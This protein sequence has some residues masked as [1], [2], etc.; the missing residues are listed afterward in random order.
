MIERFALGARPTRI[1]GI[2]FTMRRLMIATAIVAVVVGVPIVFWREGNRMIWQVE[3]DHHRSRADEGPDPK[4]KATH[5]ERSAEH[6]RL[7]E[8]SRS[9]GRIADHRIGGQASEAGGR[10]RRLARIGHVKSA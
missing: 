9:A 5:L 7:L 10:G 3:R 4:R 1:P 8:L 6:D 2:R